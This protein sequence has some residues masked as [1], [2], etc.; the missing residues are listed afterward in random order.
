MLNDTNLPIRRFKV[1]TQNNSKRRSE[2]EILKKTYFQD[3]TIM[4]N[5]EDMAEVISADSTAKV[6]QLAR[7]SRKRTDLMQQQQQQQQMQAIE[8]QKAADMEKEQL[9]HQHKMEVE[10]LKGEIALNKQAI[11]SLGFVKPGDEGAKD[12]TPMVVEQLK[13]STDALEQRFKQRI[14]EE[15]LRRQAIDSD[16]RYQIAQQELNLKEREMQTRMQV[17]NKDLQ[18]AETNKNR[19]DSK[20]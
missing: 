3:N 5:L 15:Q 10:R 2:L 8:M 20:A 14:G 11:L 12:D 18:I 1:Y 19:Y 17:A 13:A 9:K 16:R 4:K 7:L 6:I